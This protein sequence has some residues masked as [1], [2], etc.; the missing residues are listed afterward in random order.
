MTAIRLLADGARHALGEGQ[1]DDASNTLERLQ[2]LAAEA[3]DQLRR[4]SGTL[5]PVALEQGGLVQSLAGLTEWLEDEYGVE[6]RLSS[7][8]HSARE[9]DRDIAVYMIARGAA[10]SA[11]RYGASF[12]E[13]VLTIAPGAVELTVTGIGCAAHDPAVVALLRAR[14]ARIGGTLKA[15]ADPAAVRMT[16]PIV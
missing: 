1:L 5:H 2:Q 12:V 4:L 14:A 8:E 16:A 10:L 11:A 15:T 7:P 9:P 6:T 3:G 13:I